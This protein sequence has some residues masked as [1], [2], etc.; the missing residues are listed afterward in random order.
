[1]NENRR[2]LLKF[3]NKIKRGEVVK[4]VIEYFDRF[5]RFGF[6]YFKFF[7]ESFGVEFVVLNGRED[8]E[9][10]NR[11]LVEDLIVIVIFFVVRIY[12]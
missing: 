9:D 4:V 12:G 10:I 3:L 8:E 7:M 11:E 1:M 6:E 5:V 2:G